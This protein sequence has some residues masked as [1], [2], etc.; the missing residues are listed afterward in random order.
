MKTKI[1][2]PAFI[3]LFSF[4]FSLRA[5]NTYYLAFAGA[6]Y[7]LPIAS[8]NAQLK[9]MGVSTGFTDANAFGIDAGYKTDA[10]GSNGFS[11]KVTGLL[12]FHYLQKQNISSP[13]DSLKFNLAGYNM[14]FDWASFEWLGSEHYSYGRARMGFWPA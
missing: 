13:G 8:L 9:E 1:F 10:S 7:Y 5:Q 12:S 6:K 14:Q 11:G 3:I 4:S 2:I